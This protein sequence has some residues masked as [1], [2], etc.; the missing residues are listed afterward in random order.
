MTLDIINQIN[1]AASESVKEPVVEKLKD[2]DRVLEKNAQTEQKI[3]QQRAVISS[4]QSSSSGFGLN[5]SKKSGTSK[6][7]FDKKTEDSLDSFFDAKEK[8]EEEKKST[9]SYGYSSYYTNQKKEETSKQDKMRE[10]TNNIAKRAVKSAFTEWKS[11]E[12]RK[13]NSWSIFDLQEKAETERRKKVSMTFEET[14]RQRQK[15]IIKKSMLKGMM[16]AGRGIIGS[17]Y[18][19]LK[20]GGYQDERRN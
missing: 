3:E 6:V 16:I 2:E 14:K 10:Y 17:L 20:P 18:E 4:E 9:S 5:D 8:K 7:L 13:E 11:E 15:D 19:N 1:Q 12:V